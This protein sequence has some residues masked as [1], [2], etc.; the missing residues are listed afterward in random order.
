MGMKFPIAAGLLFLTTLAG[1]VG[2]DPAGANPIIEAAEKTRAQADLARASALHEESL[3]K[4]ESKRAEKIAEAEKELDEHLAKAA[5]SEA[6]GKTRE[7]DSAL[8]E[9]VRVLV[10]LDVLRGK[11]NHAALAAD[12][13]FTSTVERAQ[14][15]ATEAEARGDWVLAGEL[16]GRLSALFEDEH[17]FEA[18]ADRLTARLS[19][20]RLYAPRRLWDLN[21]ERRVLAGEEPFPAYNPYG[22]TFEE[23]LEPVRAGMVVRALQNAATRHIEPANMKA[24]LI[25]G[26]ETLRVFA[27]TEDLKTA[28]PGLGDA[29]RNRDFLAGLDE[30]IA[31]LNTR[32]GQAT[33]SDLSFVVDG[34]RE[35]NR[36]TI[37]VLEQA[38]LHEFA[39]GS[40]EELDRYTA[41]IWPDEIKRFERST[42]GRFTGVGIQIEWD[43]KF[44]IK[45]VTPLPGTPAQRAGISPGD[46]IT[47]V[48]G[49]SI[50]GFT[51]DQAVEL[52]T[53]PEHTGVRLTVERAEGEAE[54]APRKELSFELK[55]TPIDLPT[56]K[57][58]KKTGP[59]DNEWDWFADPA[60]G[61]GYVRITNFSE[62]T[63]REFDAAVAEMR[64]AGL[65][66]L[67]L[68]LR[69]NPGGLLDQAVSISN[70]FIDQGLIVKTEG[71][72]GA[73]RQREFADASL[74]ASRSLRDI[75]VAVLINNG[76][77][78]ASEIVSGAIQAYAHEGG[79]SAWVIGENSFG[80]GS[81]QNVFPIDASGEAMMKL[82]THYYKLRDDRL[83]H[84]LPDSKSWG[85]APDLQVEMLPDQIIEALELRRDADIF[86]IDIEG[87]I[88]DNAERPDPAKLINDGIDLQ[89]Q[90][91]LVRLHEA[92]A[93]VTLAAEKAATP[94][95]MQP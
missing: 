29:A 27:T 42:Q 37:G 46:I 85:I 49:Q 95:P 66:A 48:N 2:V 36:D 78:S 25:A 6:A 5:E 60:A 41:I 71:V 84:R 92:R 13:R 55:R 86:E 52:I 11:A 76:S 21:N 64:R 80:K 72:N 4:R 18:D 90:R 73:V 65:E 50:E 47:H 75:P 68:D 91:A 79:I 82:T 43:D 59:G 83:I 45:V 44:N 15:A 26:L 20:I 70:R 40:L 35:L 93:G 16:F 58:W 56:V 74:P 3:T 9:S 7:R 34:V 53:G 87:N 10:E 62:N 23:K 81:V 31:R 61:I 14:R 30:M 67:V 39:N 32:A 8:S 28:F 77:A 24:M 94:E 38:V 63:T 54:D 1:A 33:L 89:L 19:M 57:G 17:R 22:D 12:P 69:F 51:L 88:I